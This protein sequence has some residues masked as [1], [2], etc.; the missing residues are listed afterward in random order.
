MYLCSYLLSI[1]SENSMSQWVFELFYN[2]TDV[3]FPWW[4][5]W[6]RICLQCRRPGFNPGSGRSLE[7]EI[8]THVSIFAWRISWTG[9][10]WWATVHGVIESRT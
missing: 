5:R 2:I 8:V 4:L 1:E 10:D 3:H 6:Y 7:K 9:G